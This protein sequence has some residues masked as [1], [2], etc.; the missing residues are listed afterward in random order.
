[1]P[2]RARNGIRSALREHLPTV[3]LGG[4]VALAGLLPVLAAAGVIP[5]ED[6]SWNAPRWLGGLAGG[7]FVLVGLYIATWSA[8]GSVSP[9]AQRMIERLLPLVIVSI[10]TVI[11]NWVA[12]GPGE[13]EISF[14]IAGAVVAV[15]WR[16]GGEMLGRAAFAVGAVLLVAVTGVGWWGFLRGRW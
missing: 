4:I 7:L 8:V 13:R 16:G 3:V 15:V 1:M 12:F 14:G 10:M 11:A 6:A 9:S 5:T 2:G